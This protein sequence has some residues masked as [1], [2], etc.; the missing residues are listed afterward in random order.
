LFF[1]GFSLIGESEIFSE[2]RIN[3]D[4]TASGFS[5]GCI[6]LVE[7][8]LTGMYESEDS[9]KRIDKIQLFSPAFF[10]DKDEKFKRLQLMFFKKDSGTYC[11]NFLKNCGFKPE[12]KDKYF[13]L[14][15]FDELEELLYYEWNEEKIEKLKAKNILIEIY[16]GEDDKII[17]SQEALTFFRKFGEVYFIKKANH[18]LSL[19]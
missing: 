9:K 6:R 2:Y 16:L 4:V 1:S 18:N 19:N 14:G 15:T 3:T 10:N 13:K 8:I 7:N 11:D 5:Y 12:D 17:N